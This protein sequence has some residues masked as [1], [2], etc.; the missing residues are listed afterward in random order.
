VFKLSNVVHQS[1]ISSL[2]A[3]YPCGSDYLGFDVSLICHGLGL[4]LAV[5]GLGLEL[6]GLVNITSLLHV[7]QQLYETRLF[8]TDAVTRTEEPVSSYEAVTRQECK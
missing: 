5:S 2:P 3:S 1:M 7:N 6:C 8:V 4:G